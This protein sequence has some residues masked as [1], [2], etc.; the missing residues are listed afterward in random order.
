MN[1]QNAITQL[2]RNAQTFTA[3]LAGVTSDEAA[4]KAAPEKW[5]ILDV[6]NHLADE[7]RTDFRMRLNLT[8][9]HPEQD[10]PPINPEESV[11][12]PAYTGRTLD[13][14]L[15]DFLAERTNSIEWLRS[16]G[17]LDLTAVHTHPRFGSMSAG[18]LFYSWL[19]HDYRHIRQIARLR[20][21]YLAAVIAPYDVEYAG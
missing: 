13:E 14:A 21:E 2:E 10:W 9:H 5:S 12:K 17:T 19:A 3:L 18:N 6:V 4:H 15:A 1:Q 20:Y 7:E 8:L 11:K 16:L